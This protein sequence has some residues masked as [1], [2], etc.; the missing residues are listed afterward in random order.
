MPF[1]Q[2][3]PTEAERVKAWKHKN[4]EKVLNQ[5]KRRRSRARAEKRALDPTG[6]LNYGDVDGVDAPYPDEVE[7]PKVLE[8]PLGIEEPLDFT[9]ELEREQKRLTLERLRAELQKIE[10]KPYDPDR[11]PLR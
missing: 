6:E 11:P 9:E 5:G 2:H 10:R 1:G 4:P 7:K 3:K 8:E